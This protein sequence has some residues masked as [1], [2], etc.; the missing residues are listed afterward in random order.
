MEA[1]LILQF[2]IYTF[3]PIFR[4]ARPFLTFFF[5]VSKS[6]LPIVNSALPFFVVHTYYS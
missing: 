2:R 6:M 5:G 4:T 3:F 1:G